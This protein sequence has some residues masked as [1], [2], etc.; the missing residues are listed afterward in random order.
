MGGICTIDRPTN[1][2]VRL[3][4]IESHIDHHPVRQVVL[5]AGVQPFLFGV[6]GRGPLAFAH[7]DEVDEVTGVLWWVW[8]VGGLGGYG[9][10][11]GAVGKW[12]GGWVV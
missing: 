7:K 11:V 6:V 9:G 10:W 5:Q 2:S 4:L 1:E 12:V 3:C 8:W